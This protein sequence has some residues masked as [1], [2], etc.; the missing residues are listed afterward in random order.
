MVDNEAPTLILSTNEIKFSI[1]QEKLDPLNYL[2]EI[3][4]NYDQLT[5]SDVQIIDEVNYNALGKYKIIYFVK[6]N[7]NNETVKFIEVTIDDTSK[8]EIITENIQ[9]K[10]NSLFD[11]WDGVIVND[12]SDN[13][14]LISNPSSIDTS[15]IGTYIVTYTAIDPRGN[16]TKTKRQ[17]EVI[18]EKGN[19]MIGIYIGLNF[20]ITGSITTFAYLYFVKKKRK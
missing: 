18:N 5:T 15:K 13:L 19:L 14:S 10:Y 20:L 11:I 12:N 3:F 17:I 8:P 2:V 4:D 7:S 1:G 6:D 9:I 16:I